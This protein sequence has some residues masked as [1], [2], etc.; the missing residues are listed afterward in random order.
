MHSDNCNSMCTQCFFKYDDIR[1]FVNHS[2]SGFNPEELQTF[3]FNRR[4]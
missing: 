1:G 2:D 4:Q 3:K